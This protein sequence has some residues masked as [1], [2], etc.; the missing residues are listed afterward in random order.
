ME[1]DGEEARSLLGLSIASAEHGLLL[2]MLPQ[3]HM[4]LRGFRSLFFCIALLLMLISTMGCSTPVGVQRVG[5]KE[6]HYLLTASVLSTDTPSLSSLQVLSRLDLLEQFK[7]D[8]R[9]ALA[10]L[11]AVLLATYDPDRL[12]N[13]LF[14][15]AEL[16]FFYAEQSQHRH[17]GSDYQ[18]WALKGKLCSRERNPQKDETSVSRTYYLAA[19]V[20]AYA[21]LFPEDPHS[22]PIDSADPRLRLAYDLYNRSLTEGL[23]SPQ[24]EEVVLASGRHALPFGVLDIDFAAAQFSWA[25]RQVEHFMPTVDLEVRGLRN[26][27]RRP[28]IGAPLAASLAATTTALAPTGAN[29]IPPRLK[30]PVTVFLRIEAPR[31]N[32]VAGALRGRLEIYAPDQVE[33]VTINGQERPLE[34]DSTAALAYTLEEAQNVYAFEIGG[35]LKETF[36]AYFPQLQTQDGIFFLHP[37]H[38]ERIPLVLVH[39]TASSPARW[40]ELVNEIEGDPRLRDRYQIW[41]FVYE[42]GN[43]IAYSGGRLRQALQN[44]V[45]ELDPEGKAAALQRMVVIGHSQG[46][47]LTKLTAID[48]GTRFWDN[49]SKTPLDELTMESETRELFRRSLFV[50]PLPFVKRVVFISTPH[51]GSYQAAL[52]LGHLASWLVTLPSG[53][54]QRTL[55][56]MTQ[57]QDKLLTQQLEK[58]PTSIDNMNPSHPFIKT[59]ASIPVAAGITAH[60]IIP[61]LGKGPLAGGNDGV[62]EYDSAHIDGVAS[63]LVVR[64]GHS[65]QGHP[66]AI[67]EV[68]RILTE[69][70]DETEGTRSGVQQ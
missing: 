55:T 56:F 24:A 61:V 40:A 42:T 52:R 41:L 15:L 5:T 59:L 12:N 33:T 19:A 54:T 29:R 39:G 69:H 37:P 70:L 58:L 9:A 49:I 43:P 67:E 3:S 60:S 63:E 36:A 4:R 45:H 27:Y 32:L 22:T 64:F 48:S 11:H 6:A 57:N 31:R 13:R 8:P 25:G 34:F 66:K 17:G 26:R 50:T 68:R 16:S 47:L 53:L 18:C 46:G 20:Y 35:F 44:V 30:V 10:A 2:M 21:F 28:G 62:V 51:R 23:M 1:K 38:I 14:A 65:V 7:D